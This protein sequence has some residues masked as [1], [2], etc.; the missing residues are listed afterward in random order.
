M[1]WNLSVAAL[2]ASWGFIAVIVRGVDLS[3]TALAFYRVALAAVA[4]VIG[5]AIIRRL[6][7]LRVA[8]SRW[9]LLASGAGLAV[10]W[11]LF[12]QTIKLASVAVAVLLVYTAPLF[13][14]LLAPLVLPE[15][16]SLVAL[17]ALVPGGAGV[18]LI[19][20]GEGAESPRPLA[21]VLGFGAALSYALLVIINKDLTTR[22]HFTTIAFWNAAIGALVLAPF[23][24]V[25]GDAIP[26]GAEL[27]YLALLGVIF[28]AASANLYIWLLRR[29]TAQAV[30]ILSYLEPVS[31][32]LLAWAILHEP[33][34]ASVIIGGALIIA[35]GLL[36]VVLEP[37]EGVA[38]EAPPVRID[39]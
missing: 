30:G 24:P 25:A 23:V 3:A 29:V 13:L 7:L 22:L 19:A 33:L 38:V 9:R 10:H 5:L 39:A 16:R 14:A 37:R 15:R 34:G 28:T 32:A 36:V 12:F 21:I 8:A 6:D 31:A 1:R 17:A 27:A 35:A 18:T 4:I 11:F 2:A 20:L 26:A